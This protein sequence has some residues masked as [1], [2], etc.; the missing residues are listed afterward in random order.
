MGQ[1]S[2]AGGYWA[3]LNSIGTVV[4]PDTLLRW[5]RKLVQRPGPLERIVALFSDRRPPLPQHA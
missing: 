4:T 3:W 1:S 2:S 5:H